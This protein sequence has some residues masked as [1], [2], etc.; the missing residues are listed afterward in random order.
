MRSS[1]MLTPTLAVLAAVAVFA[2]VLPATAAPQGI[3]IYPQKGQSDAKKSADDGECESWARRETGFDP[4]QGPANVNTGNSHDHMA[5]RGAV[6][7]AAAGAIIG[8]IAGDAGKGAAIGAGAGLLHGAGRR[9]GEDQANSQAQ[10]QANAD[11]SRGMDQFKRAYS[12]CM[13]A[14]RYSV[15]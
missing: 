13:S 1:R 11:Y 8:A 15:N 4:N 3:Y 2:M 14:R 12:A 10:A 7:G 6:R 5:A 9:R